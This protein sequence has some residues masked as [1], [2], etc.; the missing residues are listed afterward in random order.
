MTRRFSMLLAG[1]AAL[2]LTA[3]GYIGPPLYPALNVPVIVTDLA[4][5]ERGD[6]FDVT[7]TI[8][9]L[10]TEGLAVKSLG[11]IDLRVGPNT[12][13]PFRVEQW[14]ASAARETVP[15]PS[16]PGPVQTRIPLHGFVGKEVVFAVRISNEKGRYSDWSNLFTVPVLAPLAQPAGLAWENVAEGVRLKWTEPNVTSF[17]IFRKETG[18]PEPSQ[19]GTSDQP[20]YSD[21]TAVSGK[22]YQYWV[23]G[24]HDKAESEAAGP[25]SATPKDEFPPAVPT[26]ITA[27]AGLN[28]IEL[29]WSRNEEP[30]FH[31]YRIYRSE[32]DGPFKLIAADIQAPNYSDKGVE[33]GKHY[34][35]AVTSVDET[36]NESTRSQV[37]EATAP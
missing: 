20:D 7:F 17:K 34:R 28:A 6:G 13:N 3:C 21:K 24:V 27:T 9:S 32:G 35:Y 1:A 15:T 25:I 19:I 29:S 31:G 18:D 5:V 16:R 33:S 37:V 11:S 14:A 30:D 23:Q 4:A 26:N 22:T 2:V 8:P 10:T 12:G 36:G